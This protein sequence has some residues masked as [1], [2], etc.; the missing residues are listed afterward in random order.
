MNNKRLKNFFHCFLILSIFLSSNNI[1]YADDI[2]SNDGREEL[3]EQLD[4]QEKELQDSFQPLNP[5][6]SDTIHNAN[7]NIQKIVEDNK[8][9]IGNDINVEGITNRI[10][11]FLFNLVI[12]TRTTSIIVYAIIWVVGIIYM[13]VRGSRDVTARRKAFLFIRNSTVLFFVY[14]NIPLFILWFNTDKSLI[15]KLSL[16]NS[17][18][19][20]VKFL[21]KNSLIIAGLL[22][23]AGTSRILVSKNNLPLRRQGQYLIKFSAITLLFLNV[24]P[25]AMY[26][27][28]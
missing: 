5:F 17:F 1:A 11:S 20:I 23:Y 7:D 8:A 22:A 12:K 25:L 16:F 9:T 19:S 27:I 24:V 13:S 18:Y 21:Q 14:I 2:N 3:Q 28:I 10:Q 4:Q 6:D 15:T 26:F